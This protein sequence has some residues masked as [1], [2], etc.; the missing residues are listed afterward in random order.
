[1]KRKI[2]LNIPDTEYDLTVSC[3][4]H[5][6]VR[7][8]YL[9]EQYFKDTMVELHDIKLERCEI[10]EFAN[11]PEGEAAAETEMKENIARILDLLYK[12]A[13]EQWI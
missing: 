12:E 2:I 8:N 3:T 4:A 7:A 10:D 9:N 11:R 1:M 5:V 13:V 6:K